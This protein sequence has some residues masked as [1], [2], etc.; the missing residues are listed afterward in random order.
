M[1]VSDYMAAFQQSLIQHLPG[2]EVGQTSRLFII[3]EYVARNK[4]DIYLYI[5]HDTPEKA[6]SLT[7]VKYLLPVPANNSRLFVD[8]ERVLPSVGPTFTLVDDLLGLSLADF[9]RAH[10]A[11]FAGVQGWH[12]EDIRLRD[13]AEVE[14]DP[15]RKQAIK[16]ILI[17]WKNM[18]IR[19]YRALSDIN[20][21][22][23]R[24]VS[25]RLRSKTRSRSR[26]AHTNASNV[27]SQR[28]TSRSGI[29]SSGRRSSPRPNSLSNHQSDPKPATSG[30]I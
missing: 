12:E 19:V 13:M 4:R 11:T 30:L 8:E 16:N 22:V 1:Q 29:V 17:F 15:D 7:L 27:K 20:I 5:S 18:R 3:G 9:I 26:S 2:Q 28:S 6:T 24:T 14:P 10:A 25:G 23:P 21:R